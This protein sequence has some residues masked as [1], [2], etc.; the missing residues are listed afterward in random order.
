M[1]GTIVLPVVW[2]AM[3]LPGQMQISVQLLRAGLEPAE[4]VLYQA[5]AHREVRRW[6][7][8]VC[9]MDADTGP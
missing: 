6:M 2:F 1:D 8:V 5:Q 3:Q 9:T 4:V 7:P